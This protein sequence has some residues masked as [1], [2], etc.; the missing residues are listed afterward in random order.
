MHLL[1]GDMVNGKILRVH[2]GEEVS[3]DPKA[4]DVG[5]EAAKEKEKASQRQKNIQ[6]SRKL[7]LGNLRLQPCNLWA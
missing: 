5:V 7:H 1:L 3:H 2:R 6:G 4:K